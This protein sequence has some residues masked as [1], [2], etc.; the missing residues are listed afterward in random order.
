MNMRPKTIFLDIDGT[1]LKHHGNLHNICTKD[2]KILDGVVETLN[3]WDI[4]GYNIILTTGRKESVRKFTE[5]QLRNLGIF[6]DQL[7]M[8]I[9]GGTRYIINDFK[10]DH[11]NVPTC[12][13]ITIDRDKGIGHLKDI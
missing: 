3:Y 4:H 12:H 8:G 1:I 13:A 6:Y 7:I 10:P 11:P 2:A 5:D 9:G